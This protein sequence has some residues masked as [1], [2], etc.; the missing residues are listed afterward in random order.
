MGKLGKAATEE[1]FTTRN[2]EIVRRYVTGEAAAT[3]ADD[4]G[5]SAV[6]VYRICDG[7]DRPRPNANAE[8]N[9]E[10]VRRRMSGEK[11]ADIGRDFGITRERVRQLCERE[12]VVGWHGDV[13]EDYADVGQI[14]DLHGESFGVLRNT[15]TTIMTAERDDAG[16]P[17][18]KKP[19]GYLYHV[20][21]V[22]AYMHERM[23]ARTDGI[24]DGW[25]SLAMLAE[26]TGRNPAGV[27]LQMMRRSGLEQRRIIGTKGQEVIIYPHAEAVEYINSRTRWVLREGSEALAEVI[28]EVER[29]DLL[30]DIALRHGFNLGSLETRL[31]DLG[32]HAKRHDQQQW[33]RF[34]DEERAT[35]DRMYNEGHKPS[36][37]GK[38]V[39]LRTQQVSAYIH[40]NR[41]R[42]RARLAAIP[43][44]YATHQALYRLCGEKHYQSDKTMYTSL[45]HHGITCLHIDGVGRVWHINETERLV[46]RM[47]RRKRQRQMGVSA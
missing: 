9:A 43:A 31:R 15:F 34:T 24:P 36:V 7:S 30:K 44:G 14:Y 47:A 11:L 17:Y 13:P 16:I 8:R 27:M 5:I 38:A 41:V 33:R 4:Y 45:L 32:I 25:A 22:V 40:N 28:A 1:W 23:A 3:I 18:I 20:P 10:I 46:R 35:M 12:G 29:G 26:E 2:A 37:I 19:K 6:Q 39:G 21:S 42:M